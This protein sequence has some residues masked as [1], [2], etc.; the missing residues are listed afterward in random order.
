MANALPL[1]TNLIPLAILK[2]AAAGSA[3]SL[4]NNYADLGSS[5]Q[6]FAF[7]SVRASPAN[8]SSV[9][10]LNASGSADVASFTNVIDI[11]APGGQSLINLAPSQVILP[12]Q[13]FIDVAKTGDFAVAMVG[14]I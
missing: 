9:Y 3:I 8:G 11:I 13:Y 4:V 2:P 6:Q 7:L 10:L 1:K 14:Q 12:G 5:Q